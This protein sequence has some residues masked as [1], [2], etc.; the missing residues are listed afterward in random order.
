MY[1]T[2]GRHKSIHSGR[3]SRKAGHLA[4]IPRNINRSPCAGSPGRVDG[5]LRCR[6]HRAGHR[7]G[8]GCTGSRPAPARVDR[9]AAASGRYRPGSAPQPRMRTGRWPQGR[10]AGAGENPRPPCRRGGRPSV[11]RSRWQPPA[12]R[13]PVSRGLRRAEPAA[14]VAIGRAGTGSANDWDP[15]AP[16]CPNEVSPRN[17]GR[18]GAGCA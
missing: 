11:P 9:E 3:R 2:L 17:A 7:S 12:A 5:K 4:P 13:S 6:D 10:A 18:A 15:V 1:R 16:P 8:P 14:D